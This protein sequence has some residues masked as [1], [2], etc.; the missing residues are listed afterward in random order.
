MAFSD[1]RFQCIEAKKETTILPKQVNQEPALGDDGNDRHG[2]DDRRR[3]LPRGKSSKPGDK[4][5][6]SILVAKGEEV[7]PGGSDEERDDGQHR[8][9]DQRWPSRRLGVDACHAPC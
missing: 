7:A 4:A 2:T 8:V 5:V 6:P 9:A 3:E 1:H